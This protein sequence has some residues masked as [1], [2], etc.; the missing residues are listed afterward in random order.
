MLGAAVPRDLGS[1][2]SDVSE[3]LR[4]LALPE[5]YTTEFGGQVRAQ[6]ETFRAAPPTR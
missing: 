1:V 6:R 3:R 5:G 2:A 4:G